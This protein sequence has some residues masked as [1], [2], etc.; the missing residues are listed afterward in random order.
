MKIIGSGKH[1]LGKSSDPIQSCNV[2]SSKETRISDWTKMPGKGPLSLETRYQIDRLVRPKEHRLTAG[3]L[4]LGTRHLIDR[5]LIPK[6]LHLAEGPVPL[7]TRYLIDRLLLP[8]EHRLA[9]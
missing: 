3:P 9:V 6:E 4:Q 7:G 8:K 5:L 1:Y 2:V